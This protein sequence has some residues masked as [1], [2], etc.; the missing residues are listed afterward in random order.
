MGQG[1]DINALSSAG[2]LDFNCIPFIAYRDTGLLEFH[3]KGVQVI[4][5]SPSHHNL[6]IC[7]C[8]RYQIGSCLDSICDETVGDPAE[9]IDPLD[10]HCV[11]SRFVNLGTHLVQDRGQLGH[12]RLLGCILNDGCSLG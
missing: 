2:P 3:K 5:P 8:G 4:R 9:H 1:D 11:A 10:S 6:S 12:L 7:Q